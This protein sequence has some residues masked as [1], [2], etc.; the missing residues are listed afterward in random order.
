MS[1]GEVCCI[2]GV[3]CPPAKR[4]GTMIAHLAADTGVSTAHAE[5]AVDWVLERFDL[6]PKGFV[7]PLVRHIAEQAR[8]HPH[9]DD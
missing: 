2:L 8:L 6:G 1:N 4:R 5:A 9:D 7:T 3:C